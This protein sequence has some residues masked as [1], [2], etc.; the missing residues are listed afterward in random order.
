MLDYPFVCILSF[1]NRN[2]I[3]EKSFDSICFRLINKHLMPNQMYQLSS[4]FIYSITNVYSTIFS[5]FHHKGD[6]WHI[7]RTWF[8][9]EQNSRIETNETA[10][11][12]R[13]GTVKTKETSYGKY[14]K[15]FQVCFC[16]SVGVFSVPLIPWN[17][18]FLIIILLC[19]GARRRTLPFLC[20]KTQKFLR[21]C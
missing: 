14:Q 7:K 2:L 5:L 16:T 3:I 1:Y 13:V 17:I 10:T 4:F 21:L 19:V 18:I 6:R 12:T 20:F 11:D 8:T 15:C 9:F